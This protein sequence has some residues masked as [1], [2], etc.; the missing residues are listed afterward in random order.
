MSSLYRAG[1]IPYLAITLF[2][3]L[4]PFIFIL[5]R[6]I[7]YRTYY[8]VEFVGL[9]FFA[10]ITSDYYEAL[11]NSIFIALLVSLLNFLIAFPP[12]YI[13]SR[14]E[15]RYKR[16]LTVL[17]IVPMFTPDVVAGIGLMSV[18]IKYY[19]LY[20]TIPGTV[21]ALASISYPMMFLPLLASLRTL[22]PVYE[23]AAYTLGARPVHVITRIVLPLI[24]PGIFSGFVLTFVWCLNDYL[25]PL[26]VTGP[27][28]DL[29]A[30]KL[31]SD[32]RWW[33]LLG[34]VAAEAS[35]LQLATFAI[36]LLYMWIVGKRYSG[37][38]AL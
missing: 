1:K 24:A 5:Y 18:F 11:R 7:T 9:G 26:F 38:F 32:V 6:A 15:F 31:Y 27:A 21:I 14:Y 16:L 30:V 23:E 17:L 29:L 4:S 34:R 2:L 28:I 13:I 25:L 19:K 22:N 33:G 36:V 35:I 10:T 12:A 20:A 8:G 37:G 3:I